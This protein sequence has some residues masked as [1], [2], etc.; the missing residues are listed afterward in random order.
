MDERSDERAPE[1]LGGDARVR[2]QRFYNALL[3]CDIQRA[4]DAYDY[5]SHAWAD[6]TRAPMVGLWLYNRFSRKFELNGLASDDESIP[7]KDAPQLSDESVFYLV[8]QTR[9]PEFA[10]D[11]RTWS[12][13][14]DDRRYSV[15]TR[16][17]LAASGYISALYVPILNGSVAAAAAADAGE[18]VEGILSLHFRA[19]AA[20]RWPLPRQVQGEPDAD[21]RDSLILMGSL[22]ALLI[23]K[24]RLRQQAEIGDQLA[25]LAGQHLTR[26]KDDP[27]A[28]RRDYLAAVLGI[29]ESELR[30]LAASVWWRHPFETSLSC[31]ISRGGLLRV[32]DDQRLLKASE[33][34]NAEYNPKDWDDDP[35]RESWTY[36]A[37]RTGAHM[38]W[39]PS[40]SPP[41]QP[42]YRDLV[43]GEHH[44]PSPVLLMPICASGGPDP[45][46]PSGAGALGVIRCAHRPA[47]LFTDARTTFDIVEVRILEFIARQIAP[48]LHALEA[49]ILRE[50]A[51]R[52]IKHDM[53][54]ALGSIRDIVNEL[55]RSLPGQSDDMQ[56]S[57]RNLQECVMSTSGLTDRLAR[58]VEVRLRV[59][60]RKIDLGTQ[61]M[62][63][64]KRLLTPY[65]QIE[66]RMEIRFDG[67]ELLPPL[68]V[69]PTLI[70]RA[71]Y[72]LIV[73]AIKYGEH[74]TT[75]RIDALILPE[76]YAI[77]VSNRGPGVREEDIPSLFR[78]YFRS[79]YVRG[80]GSGL[81]LAIV[82]QIMRSH[83][84]QARLQRPRDPTVF[85][86][87]FP[88]SRAAVGRRA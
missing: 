17:A 69:D 4:E 59:E 85:R 64:I 63:R 56:L 77:D 25:R 37:F 19:D 20:R 27:R 50:D 28:V 60:P 52:V 35:T 31:L 88:A 26:A 74:G 61:L 82:R 6:C 47:V 51:I 84:G 53:A 76:G 72:N 36:R 78:M 12:R 86:L 23:A 87:L 33:I 48:V 68:N 81:G 22:T 16:E 3:T 34:A 46:N 66:S 62:P 54:A 2:R 71:L 70:E 7:F 40:E 1:P 11:V 24:L 15:V 45:A 80:E 30:I 42:K 79:R 83:D 41:H 10:A 75:I 57:L 67:F 14:L 9:A 58:D 73:N 49:R 55:D 43:G 5:I 13:A 18:R 8:R 21:A 39:I 38:L 65:A 29:L 32:G 44:G